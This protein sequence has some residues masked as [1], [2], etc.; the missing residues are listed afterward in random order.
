MG[1][2]EIG[3]NLIKYSFFFKTLYEQYNKYSP[4]VY[5]IYLVKPLFENK[6]RLAWIIVCFLL[7]SMFKRFARNPT[8]KL[9]STPD[10]KV[11]NVNFRTFH[12]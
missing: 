1:S 8:T 4:I 6:K 12:F 3:K 7:L 9:L 10:S 11:H 5:I 2:A